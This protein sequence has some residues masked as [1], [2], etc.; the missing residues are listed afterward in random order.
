MNQSNQSIVRARLLRGTRST[1]PSSAPIGITV[2]EDVDN[3]DSPDQP[4]ADVTVT[5]IYSSVGCHDNKIP[6][7]PQHLQTVHM[8]SPV[9]LQAAIL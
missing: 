7:P 6:K 9:F 3:D 4:I 5:L 1:A 8:N 2:F